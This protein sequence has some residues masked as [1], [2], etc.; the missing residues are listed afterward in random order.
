MHFFFF[1]TP[2]AYPSNQWTSRSSALCLWTGLCL[3]GSPKC[4]GDPYITRDMGTMGVPISW[5]SQ[6]HGGPISRLLQISALLLPPG[7][8]SLGGSH[9]LAAKPQSWASKALYT[10]RWLFFSLPNWLPRKGK[11]WAYLSIQLKITCLQWCKPS[12]YPE[13]FCVI[14]ALCNQS[15]LSR[16]W[17]LMLVLYGTQSCCDFLLHHSPSQSTSL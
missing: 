3:P 16:T 5:G 15:S 8:T 11:E 6:Y 17:W 9:P 4:W 13:Y 2:M 12:L 1:I 10:D 14:K 7:P